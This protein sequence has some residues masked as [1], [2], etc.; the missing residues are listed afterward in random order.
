MKRIHKTFA[1]ITST[2][3]LALMFSSTAAF[4][5]P[6]GHEAKPS[7]DGIGGP[8]S[9]SEPCEL[10]EIQKQ[11][12][13]KEFEIAIKSVDERMSALKELETEMR[14]AESSRKIALTITTV[15]VLGAIASG[16]LFLNTANAAHPLIRG[17]EGLV[18]EAFGVGVSAVTAV[19]GIIYFTVSH[20]NL[21][22]ARAIVEAKKAE[23]ISARQLQEK[24]MKLL[25][26]CK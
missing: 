16:A 22:K 6:K 11:A 19:G 17:S 24:L 8:A 21:K 20:G 14:K 12:L 9:K 25:L 10:S 4:S 13:K 2:L 26:D 7:G 15:G 5:Q 18:L 1:T 3:F 23:L